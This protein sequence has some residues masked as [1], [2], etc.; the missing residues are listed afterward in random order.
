ML[1]LNKNQLEKVFIVSKRLMVNGFQPSE[2][3]ICHRLLVL[4]SGVQSILL[5]SLNTVLFELKSIFNLVGK[6]THKKFA[7]FFYMTHEM[8][9][10]QPWPFQRM[11]QKVH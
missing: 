5:L 10:C 6:Q 9:C 2:Y 8:H 3:I 4:Y 11:F 1:S 7:H